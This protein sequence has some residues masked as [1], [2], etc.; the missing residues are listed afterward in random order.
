MPLALSETYIFTY[1]THLLHMPKCSGL[2]EHI[3]K[4]LL[5]IMDRC[6]RGLQYVVLTVLLVLELRQY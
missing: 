6:L 2:L 4:H 1:S 3:D 5:F